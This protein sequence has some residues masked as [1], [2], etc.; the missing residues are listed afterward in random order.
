MDQ[1]RAEGRASA[2]AFNGAVD[3]AGT[4]EGNGAGAGIGANG[5]NGDNGT[6]A[7]MGADGADGG[8]GP[9]VVTIDT[10]AIR[11]VVDIRNGLPQQRVANNPAHP[12]GILSAGLQV[13]QPAMQPVHVQ[14][15]GCCRRICNWFCCK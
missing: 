3:R 12:N 14:Q 7:G 1:R 15:I 9:G 5:G 6:G 13:Q 8:N 10:G 2:G 4:N 11:G